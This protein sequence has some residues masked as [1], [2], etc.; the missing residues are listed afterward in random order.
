MPSPRL[1]WEN[2]GGLEFEAV[3]LSVT[4]SAIQLSASGFFPG[5]GG[6]PPDRGELHLPDGRVIAISHA[7]RG[8]GDACWHHTES[9]P[10]GDLIGCSVS[11]KV[12]AGYRTALSRPHTALHILNAIALRDHGG[13]ITGC[14]IGTEISRID[15]KVETPLTSLAADLEAKT[16][17]VIE[18]ALEVSSRFVPEAEFGDD[19]VRTLEARPPVIAGQVRVIDIAGFDSQACGG[20]HASNTAELGRLSVVRT[21][22][23]GRINKRLYIRLG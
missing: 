8:E 19:F 16:R 3:V 2:D 23:K 7:S 22:N 1:Y 10:P 13:W 18:A 15:F 20:T 5:G 6:Q 21:E 9:P 12:D 17:A 11:G 4:E 14:Q